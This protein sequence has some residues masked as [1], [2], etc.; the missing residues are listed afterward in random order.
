MCISS[1]ATLCLF[2]FVWWWPGPD[3]EGSDIPVR[4]LVH[5]PFLGLLGLKLLGII[6]ESQVNWWR[7]YARRCCCPTL[8]VSTAILCARTFWIHHLVLSLDLPP[9]VHSIIS[10]ARYS[11]R[12]D[13]TF[14]WVIPRLLSWEFASCLLSAAIWVPTCPGWGLAIEL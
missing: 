4:R 14:F 11:S 3:L 8:F 9:R 7:V 5:F 2:R 12:T 1:D 13:I 10:I 6:L